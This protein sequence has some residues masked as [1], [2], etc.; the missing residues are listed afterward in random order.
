MARRQVQRVK[1]EA[2]DAELSARHRATAQR[3]ARERVERLERALVELGKVEMVRSQQ[4]GGRRAKGEP[5][6]STTDPEARKLRMGDGGYRPGYN[7]QLA[8]E[9]Q[10]NVIVGVSVTNGLDQGE[11]VPMIEQIEQRTGERPKEYLVDGGYTGKATVEAVSEL[12]VTLYGP[13]VDRYGQ[14]PFTPKMTDSQAVAQWRKRMAT[15][16]AQEIYRERAEYS[17]HVNADVK[18]HRTLDRMLVRGANK[19]LSVA[20]WNALA[21][22]VLRWITLGG[23]S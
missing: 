2:E 12:G 23:S 7:V 17:E 11:V 14:A 1:R 6:A 22:N 5:R 18:T 16:E 9:T 10:N 4:T 15:V 13:V 8:T 21:Y 3:V 20:L 19:V